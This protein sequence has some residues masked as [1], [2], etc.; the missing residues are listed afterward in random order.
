MTAPAS[1]LPPWN[2]AFRPYAERDFRVELRTPISFPGGRVIKDVAG[3]FLR[4]PMWR[5]EPFSD[6]FG[7]KSAAMIELGGEHLFAELAVLRLLQAD[8]WD[9][10]WVNTYSGG[11]EVWKYLTDWQDVSRSEQRTRPIHDSDARQLLARIANFNKPRRYKGCW[12][13]FCWRSAE[14]AFIECKRTSSKYTDLVSKEQEEWLRSALFIGDPRVTLDSFC[15][16]QW[17]YQ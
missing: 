10:R 17:D 9:G 8:G 11:G 13:T 4:F 15:F 7:K 14:F 3:L 16:V 2:S 12:D 1:G 6:D 5:G